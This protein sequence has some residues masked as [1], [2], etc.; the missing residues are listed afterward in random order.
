M[1]N[2]DIF[3]GIP[4]FITSDCFNIGINIFEYTLPQFMSQKE[5]ELSFSI[6][7]S[8]TRLA[9][10]AIPFTNYFWKFYVFMTPQVLIGVSGLFGVLM[11]NKMKTL[12]ED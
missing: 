10:L 6:I 9:N 8:V 4:I 2:I 7:P 5:V 12:D 1:K 11:M 3:Q